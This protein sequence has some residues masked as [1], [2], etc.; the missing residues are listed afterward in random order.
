MLPPFAFWKISGREKPFLAAVFRVG[1][2]NSGV[3]AG[4]DDDGGGVECAGHV[5]CGGIHRQDEAS[6]GDGLQEIGERDRRGE[7]DVGDASGLKNAGEFLE[8]VC[9]AWPGGEVEW[10]FSALVVNEF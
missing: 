9:L 8:T 2:V 10:G 7:V 5:G 3:L 4:G 6:F 1:G